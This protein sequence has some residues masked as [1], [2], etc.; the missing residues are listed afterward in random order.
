MTYIDH[1]HDVQ[2][3]VAALGP[4]Q[5]P[6]SPFSSKLGVVASTPEQ[7]AHQQQVTW[8]NMFYSVV[9]FIYSSFNQWCVGNDT[10]L[11]LR[12]SQPNKLFYECCKVTRARLHC[13]DHLLSPCLVTIFRWPPWCPPSP[14]TRWPPSRQ[15]SWRPS[16]YR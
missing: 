3:G 2:V 14:Q 1:A 7:L 6:P 15:R 9:Y 8:S 4:L 5:G 11:T 16:P 12:I 13:T 10:I